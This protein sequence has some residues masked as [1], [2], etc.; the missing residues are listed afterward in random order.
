MAIWWGGGHPRGTE[1]DRAPAKTRR[2]RALQLQSQW[3]EVTERERRARVRNQQLLEDFQ[4]AQ[5]TLRDLVARTVAMATIRMEYER[6]LEQHFP[7]WQ[8]RF[9]EKRISVQGKEVALHFKEA[10]RKMEEEEDREAHR[11]T[12][13]G[14]N[15]PSLSPGPS[16]LP[17]TPILP[18]SLTVSGKGETHLHMLQKNKKVTK[19]NSAQ[20]YPCTPW[21]PSVHS[22]WLTG[23][24]SSPGVS[25]ASYIQDPR[26][27][28]DLR[29]LQD[30]ARAEYPFQHP[31]HRLVSQP[32]DPCWLLPQE[33]P[34]RGPIVGY[35]PGWPGLCS[36]PRLQSPYVQGPWPGFPI[37]DPRDW[38]MALPRE[39]DAEGDSAT[40]RGERERS[41]G[42]ESL[43]DS[44]QGQ[45]VYKRPLRASNQSYE[46]DIKPV[47]LSS[48]RADS[49][50]DSSVCSE[51]PQGDAAGV[52]RRRRRRENKGGMPQSRMK[53]EEATSQRSSAG[54]SVSSLTGSGVV[55]ATDSRATFEARSQRSGIPLATAPSIEQEE[56]HSQEE[57]SGSAG[58]ETEGAVNQGTEDAQETQD[59]SQRD[60]GI[61][62]E[63]DEDGEKE[64][65]DE[66]ED[67]EEEVEKTEAAEEREGEM[68][69]DS[70]VEQDVHE[71]EDGSGDEGSV[72]GEVSSCAEDAEAERTGGVLEQ[73]EEVVEVGKRLKLSA[74]EVGEEDPSSERNGNSEEEEETEGRL[75]E[76]VE[77]SVGSE[78][79]EE[80]DDRQ[81][82][83][84]EEEEA[85]EQ[86]SC[87]QE[88]NGE[89]EGEGSGSL[90]EGETEEGE[91]SE[92]GNDAVEE[93]EEDDDEEVG[94]GGAEAAADNRKEES[95]GT[96]DSEDEIITSQ[97]DKRNDTTR[98]A[99]VG[100]KCKTR[101][102]GN[103]GDIE[104]E[105]EDEDAEQIAEKEY[106]ENESNDNKKLNHGYEDDSE[107][108]EYIE[109]LLA[110][111]KDSSIH[112]VCVA[113]KKEVPDPASPMVREPK[114][115]PT[116]PQRVKEQII[117]VQ[118]KALWQD[119]DSDLGDNV[120]G[121]SDVT[122]PLKDVLEDFDEFYD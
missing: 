119:S 63:E 71:G 88:E 45:Q 93:D 17:T 29:G 69:E 34:H 13:K 65:E 31:L 100:I 4:R 59:S 101:A 108:G 54:S 79:E 9:E 48:G 6:Q 122:T 107:D 112:E 64:G 55:R 98:K 103:M 41:E 60:G 90:E 28:P 94:T 43:K 30:L 113:E 78:E 76:D 104:E 96:T 11:R 24:Q 68:I 44:R 51:P 92:E 81:E 37:V 2:S 49:S 120:P 36:V 117:T 38:G 62:D 21:K 114:G 99:D 115:K 50:E 19:E 73:A 46:L 70:D 80:E 10:L 40:T 20:S 5:D 61:T 97:V 32:F 26:S 77:E 83:E 42:P 87:S 27:P 47:R 1:H 121:R 67:D 53:R 7:Q 111:K 106:Y 102:G 66:K 74:K 25:Q 18:H 89:D 56:N 82:E 91:E 86:E 52:R 116:C 22:S 14:V 72:E 95:E 75:E 105:G 16:L 57:A 109:G 8:Q 58:A 118:S 85:D 3:Q 15:A 39:P 84:D 35:P 33:Q 110:P 12:T 23:A